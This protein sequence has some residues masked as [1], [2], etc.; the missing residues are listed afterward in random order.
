MIFVFLLFV[1]NK[2]TNIVTFN[3]VKSKIQ[4]N[5]EFASGYLFNVPKEWGKQRVQ[6]SRSMDSKYCCL[7]KII[8]I[9]YGLKQKF[10]C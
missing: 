7:P 3:V 4:L 2:F 5:Q 6:F 8:W 9:R 10:D 1:R